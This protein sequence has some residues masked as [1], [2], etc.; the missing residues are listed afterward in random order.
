MLSELDLKEREQEQLVL[1]IAALKK[2]LDV[3][4]SA[5]KIVSPSVDG[6]QLV[7][8]GISPAVS[9]PSDFYHVMNE[10]NDL[11]DKL[12]SS[13][14]SNQE[15]S[16]HLRHRLNQDSRPISEVRMETLKDGPK[17]SLSDTSCSTAALS[18]DVESSSHPQ[19]VSM[20]TSTQ[21]TNKVSRK[22]SD[23]DPSSNEKGFTHGSPDAPGSKIPPL[24]FIHPTAFS[25]PFSHQMLNCDEPSILSNLPTSTAGRHPKGHHSYHGD[26]RHGNHGLS[27]QSR[28]AAGSSS[29]ATQYNEPRDQGT[30]LSSLEPKGGSP[31]GVETQYNEPRDQGTQLSGSSHKSTQMSPIAT[32]QATPMATS[33]VSPMATSQVTPMATSQVSPMATSQVTPMATSQISP[34]LFSSMVN[35]RQDSFVEKMEQGM[36]APTWTHHHL[37]P[38]GGKQGWTRKVSPA[39]QT[40]HYDSDDSTSTC[41]STPMRGGLPSNHL[42]G[43]RRRQRGDLPLPISGPHSHKVTP[44]LSGLALYRN[45]STQTVHTGSISQEGSDVAMV[46][47]PPVGTIDA[48]IQTVQEAKMK[49]TDLLAGADLKVI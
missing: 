29:K 16:E 12:Q 40:R 7:D 34:G 4:H 3:M 17:D 38:T 42:L 30:Q 32:S 45:T 2:E 18:V 8:R 39:K 33:Q 37:S 10:V 41:S 49:V 15:L 11:K 6:P 35:G 31:H 13:I 20:A 21:Y 28:P 14:H 43:T 48:V 19:T 1:Q 23:K 27:H 47:D 26:G 36:S 9:L 22:S 24:S 44:L 5:N 46:T 25:T